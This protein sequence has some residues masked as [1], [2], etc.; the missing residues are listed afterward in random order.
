M[1]QIWLEAPVMDGRDARRHVGPFVARE[2]GELGRLLVVS[3]MD[4]ARRV[5]DGG[6]DFWV[7]D[8]VHILGEVVAV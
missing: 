6:R 2:A 3:S 1:H 4:V 8:D 5:R 7:V